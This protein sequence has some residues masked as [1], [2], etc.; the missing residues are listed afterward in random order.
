MIIVA[1][2]PPPDYLLTYLPTPFCYTQCL[3]LLF[4]L[5]HRTSRDL[6]I[7]KSQ[8]S[9]YFCTMFPG[10][11]RAFLDPAKGAKPQ[12]AD[13]VMVLFAFVLES[14]AYVSDSYDSVPVGPDSV[15]YAS[16]IV[17]D[18]DRFVSGADSSVSDAGA[19]I[20]D[21]NGF[22]PDASQSAPLPGQSVRMT[23]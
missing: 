12:K 10:A 2:N 17:P 15:P 9:E 13:P 19:S 23:K 18:A 21:A 22:V 7:K 3:N 16:G 8:G 1:Q 6:E 5:E 11:I 4:A 14:L 20:T